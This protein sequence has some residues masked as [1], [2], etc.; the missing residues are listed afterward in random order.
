MASS[1]RSVTGSMLASSDIAEAVG[2]AL[3]SAVRRSW[4]ECA[5][6][7]MTRTSG[8]RE[9]SA[10]GASVGTGRDDRSLEAGHATS[11]C[12]AC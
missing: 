2:R 1:P 4:T 9:P 11:G 7:H 12:D 10:N 6:T 5:C 3:A 8:I